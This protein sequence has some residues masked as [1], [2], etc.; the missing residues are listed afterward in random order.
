M[1]ETRNSGS[2]FG[3]GN[4]VT[5][6]DAEITGIR[7]PTY[8]QVLRCYKY[9]QEQG[10][11]DKKTKRD[12]AK[13]VLDKVKQFYEKG[14]IPMTADK[15]ACEKIID[16]SE[17]N[18]TLRCTPVKRRSE[19]SVQAK[20]DK[21]KE[22]FKKTF[23]LWA[24]NA[25]EM[26]KIPEDIAFL[27]SMK[28]DRVATFAGYDKQFAQKVQRKNKRELEELERK[29]RHKRQKKSTTT[30]EL[31]S[32]EDHDNDEEDD[33]NDAEAEQD[34][35]PGPSNSSHKRKARPGTPAFIPHDILRS[36]KLVSIAAR[37]K[38][39][40][41]QQAAFTKAIIK[42]SG[43]DSSKVTIS[44]ASCDRARRTGASDIAKNVKRLWMPPPIGSL[45][46]DS[47]IMNSLQNSYVN[48]DRL[49]VL[50]GDSQDVKL[51]G[52]AKYPPGQD[53]QAGDIIADHT[54]G[55]LNSWQC[56]VNVKNLVFDTTSA[57]TGHLTAACIKIQ[58]SLQKPLLWSGCRHHV[59][60]LVLKHVFTALNIEASKSPEVSVFKR[61]R[62]NFD[63]VQHAGPDVNLKLFT[64]QGFSDEAQELIHDWRAAALQ[65]VEVTTAYQREDY[66]EFAK[67]VKTYFGE[68]ADEIKFRQPG[69][70][71]KAR[72]MSKV[73][74]IL[75][76]AMLETEIQTLPRGTITTSQQTP[77]IVEFAN[78][79]ALVYFRW[80]ATCPCVA[81]A[82]V[83]DLNF[84]RTIISYSKINSAVSA[85]AETA[86]RRHLWYL[87]SEFVPLALFSDQ[88]NWNER[89]DLATKLLEMK[90]DDETLASLPL[91]R[92]GSDYGKPNFPD[93]Q[94]LTSKTRLC[95]LV[96][97][98]SWF[99]FKLLGLDSDFMYKDLSEWSELESYK[100]SAAKVKK[101]NITNDSAERAVKLS[102]DYLDAAKKRRTLPK[103]T[104]SGRKRSQRNSRPEKSE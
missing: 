68:N 38:M 49:S 93:T 96:S 67:L 72:F 37:M 20:I 59:G 90:P 2:I 65:T 17:R 78:F 60:E 9:H 46:W 6:E 7:L 11:S 62:E 82:P 76:L 25:E 34:Q 70:I 86:F 74:Y 55:L 77:K 87:T 83:N 35:I 22:E 95:D 27:T 15:T 104:P 58:S 18:R 88:L 85:V 84:L 80:W 66:A 75:K 89:R 81:D 26:I 29:E 36:P 47:K 41:T 12:I 14:N 61:F 48:E 69:A 10:L 39:T 64:L 24:R 100:N 13:I 30:I 44:Y 23:P 19:P 16:Y 102:S 56:S 21:Q 43:G 97:K 73:L 54:I 4:K 79:I 103:Y 91:E 94:T 98:D 99:I 40:P 42:E 92:Y 63:K 8:G 1:S 52:T 50:V 32:D 3:F 28:T 57:N 53:R 33:G 51:L 101:L 45:H 71:H 5:A 31:V